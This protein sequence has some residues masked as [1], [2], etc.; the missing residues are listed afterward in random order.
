MVYF[1]R[2]DITNGWHTESDLAL[3]AHHEPRLVAHF[4]TGMALLALV[5]CRRQFCWALGRGYTKFQ[6]SPVHRSASAAIFL[7]YRQ[8]LH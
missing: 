3:A 7:R 1:A 4:I 5:A 2:R 6:K 8:E